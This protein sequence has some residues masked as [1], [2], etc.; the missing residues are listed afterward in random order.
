MSDYQSYA[1]QAAAKFGIPQ[2]IFS[3]LI[4]TE[5]NWN[6]NAVSSAGAV[7]LTQ[8]LPSTAA[9][10][11]V[12]PHDPL[13]NIAGG[14][15]YLASLFKQFG[16]WPDALAAYNI[17]PGNFASGNDL[18]TGQAYAA[19]VLNGASAAGYVAPT[20]SN[21]AAS[22]LPAWMQEVLTYIGLPNVSF[23]N[24]AIYAITVAVLLLVAFFGVK[25]LFPSTVKMVTSDA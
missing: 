16:N 25:A 3:S 4:N 5:S 20:A 15:D 9:S 1:D 14:A 18:A 6:A 11:G 12:D 21:A 23:A 7:G 10:L 2:Q 8:L 19:K 17:G 22:D 13:Q 24:L